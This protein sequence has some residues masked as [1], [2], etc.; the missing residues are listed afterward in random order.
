MTAPSRKT[1]EECT[2]SHTAL[3]QSNPP[4]VT[5]KLHHPIVLPSPKAPKPLGQSLDNPGSYGSLGGKGPNYLLTAAARLGQVKAA[6]TLAS[7]PGMVSRPHRVKRLKLA[8]APM[9]RS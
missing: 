3:A 1:R 6:R 5:P 9:K 4:P 7:G 2:R 8:E